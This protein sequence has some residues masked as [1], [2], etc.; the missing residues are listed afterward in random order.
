VGHPRG[1]T[2]GSKRKA[3]GLQGLSYKRRN[4]G[5]GA[6]GWGSSEEERIVGEGVDGGLV[7]VELGGVVDGAVVM[8]LSPVMFEK[9]EDASGAEGQLGDGGGSFEATAFATYG[10]EDFAGDVERVIVELN[11]DASR[12]G[13]KLFVDAPDFGPAAFDAA[14]G[15]VHGNFVEG[16]PILP[17]EDDV[18][19]IKCAIKLRES[20]TRMREIAKVFVTGDGIERGGKSG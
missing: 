16:R 1:K 9:A 2:R 3:S 20:V 7:E 4:G 11:G 8:D 14:E 6:E 13:K 15:I 10:K 18:A 17:H 19:G 12:A 5:S